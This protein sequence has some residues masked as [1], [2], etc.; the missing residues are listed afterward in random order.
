MTYEKRTIIHDDNEFRFNNASSHEGSLQ[1]NGILI[2]S[3]E[4]T[5][6]YNITNNIMFNDNK[7]A[8]NY[9]QSVTL[10]ICEFV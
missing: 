1:L 7:D 9:N 6:I 5:N 3:N 8:C 4:Y 10:S 2:W